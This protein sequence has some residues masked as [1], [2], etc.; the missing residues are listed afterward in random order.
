M[1]IHLSDMHLPTPTSRARHLSLRSLT[2]PLAA[3]I[4]LLDC[5]T[6]GAQALNERVIQLDHEP[7]WVSSAVWVD[8]LARLAV[9]DPLQDSIRLYDLEGNSVPMR[10]GEIEPNAS[11]L[12]TTLNKVGTDYLLRTLTVGDIYLDSDFR[13]RWSGDLWAG[14]ETSEDRDRLGSLFTGWELAQDGKIY[15]YGSLLRSRTRHSTSSG[16]EVRQEAEFGFL[17]AS[18]HPD[19]FVV[20]EAEMLLP[21]NDHDFYTFG[22]PTVAVT[23]SYAYFL[24]ISY[25]DGLSAIY[26]TRLGTGSA[27][28]SPID[29]KGFNLPD[30]PEVLTE[31]T[32][33]ENESARYSEL[34]S[35]T[36][37]AALIGRGSRLFVLMRNP[38]VVDPEAATW[39]LIE[40]DETSSKVINRQRLSTRSSQITLVPLRDKEWIILER[41]P[42]GELGAQRISS[43]RVLAQ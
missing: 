14:Y 3:F 8:N 27:S 1:T 21:L 6:V 23:E 40:L 20:G 13:E 5:H 22:L 26:R 33:P 30:P 42:V 31:N 38:S 7:S 37:P 15:A 25:S 24:A 28:A 19:T 35:R 10:P 18:F 11:I 12:P 41:G 32:G 4:A 36:F 17:R 2:V 29:F 16:L 34:H 9:V 39:D 43:M